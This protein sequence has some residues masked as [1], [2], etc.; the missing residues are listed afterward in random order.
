MSFFAFCVDS[1][2]SNYLKRSPLAFI[3]SLKSKFYLWNVRP[4]AR[5]KQRRTNCTDY[6]SALRLRTWSLQGAAE[7]ADY[8]RVSLRGKNETYLWEMGR[9]S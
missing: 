3:K 4:S 7:L 8:R 2:L 1:Q 5:M 9:Q 6:F